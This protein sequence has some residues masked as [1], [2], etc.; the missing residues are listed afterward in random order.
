MARKRK[1]TEQIK[2][3]K[4]L[5]EYD[6][7]TG[8]GKINGESAYILDPSKELSFRHMLVAELG[9]LGYKGSDIAKMLKTNPEK[10]DGGHY[11]RLLRDP[12]ILTQ[13]KEKLADNTKAAKEILRESLTTAAQNVAAAVDRGDLKQS[14][15][16]LGTQGI[17]A[18]PQNNNTTNINVGFGEWL[19]QVD[20]ID[21]T[22]GETTHYLPHEEDE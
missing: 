3:L 7:V 15:Y 5:E 8:L 14:Q 10:S 9:S 12:K 1:D 6:E 22:P 18:R 17:S 2:Q 4:G 16:V 13:T 19:K 11:A 21:V 20:A